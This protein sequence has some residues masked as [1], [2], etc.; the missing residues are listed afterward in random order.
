M[1]GNVVQAM[2]GNGA[3]YKVWY[4]PNDRGNGSADLWREWTNWNTLGYNQVGYAQTF[5]G[6]ASYGPYQGWEFETNPEPGSSAPP[7]S[8]TPSERIFPSS[9]PL[10]PEVLL[11]NAHHPWR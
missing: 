6:T 3:T 2:T 5:P 4:D 8:P 1:S 7:P 9:L 10:V 11:R